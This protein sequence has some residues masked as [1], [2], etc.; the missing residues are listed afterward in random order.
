MLLDN[1]SKIIDYVD[2]RKKTA[3]ILD[4]IGGEPLLEIQLID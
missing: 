1:D 2:T 4:F 3:A